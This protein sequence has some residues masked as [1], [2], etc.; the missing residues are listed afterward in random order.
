VRESLFARLDVE[1]AVVLD[2]YAGSGA[3]GCEALSRGAAAA[4]FVE[5]SARP[6]AL[7][8]TNLRALGLEARSE[9]RSGEACRVVGRLAREGRRFHLALLDPPYASGELERALRALRDA[10]ILAPGGL[11]VMESSRRH[12]VPIVEGFR[13]QD[14]RRYGDT[15]V[16]RLRPEPAEDAGR[17]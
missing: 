4:V 8:R 11:V 17:A 16:T 7:L 5:R 6:L 3:L 12:P 2:L 1:G 15:L 10:G 14:Q 13:V 9:V